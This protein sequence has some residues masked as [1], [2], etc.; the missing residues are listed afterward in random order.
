MTQNFRS[1]DAGLFGLQMKDRGYT[2]VDSRKMTKI[3]TLLAHACYR[4]SDRSMAVDR[5]TYFL[6]E[7]KEKGML[8]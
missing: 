2:S 3:F 5:A 8:F 7:M 4:A 1:E 6:D